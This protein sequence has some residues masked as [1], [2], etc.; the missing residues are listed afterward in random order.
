MNTSVIA[1]VT[2]VLFLAIAIICLFMPETIQRFALEYYAAHDGARRVNPFFEWM[3]TPGYLVSLRV[4]GLI[5][6]LGCIWIVLAG[7]RGR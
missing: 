5:A 1:L 3:R 4:I 7:V 6:L 2:V